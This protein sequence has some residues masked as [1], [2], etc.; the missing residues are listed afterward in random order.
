[1]W[2]HRL[3][4]QPPCRGSGSG[5]Q[6]GSGEAPLPI[7]LRSAVV[8]PAG[9]GFRCGN[10]KVCIREGRSNLIT[11]GDIRLYRKEHTAQGRKPATINRELHYLGQALRLAQER[12]LLERVP[13]IRN[14]PEDN[15]RQGFFEHQE[16]ERLMPLL[17]EDLQ[18]FARFAYYSG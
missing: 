9:P 13:R 6:G 5:T 17:P 16:F 15:A 7:E 14:E 11:V 12:E 18:D 4:Q 1:L 8:G 2:R 3:A 10:G